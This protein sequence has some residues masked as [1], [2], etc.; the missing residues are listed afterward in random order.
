MKSILL[1]KSSAWKQQMIFVYYSVGRLFIYLC[2]KSLENQRD[3][4]IVF[5]GEYQVA[6]GEDI[7]GYFE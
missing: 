6:K 4:D 2:K 7:Y 1:R 3:C 5:R